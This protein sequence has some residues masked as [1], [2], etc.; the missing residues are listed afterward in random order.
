VREMVAEATDSH[1]HCNCRDAD[2]MCD[3]C[4]YMAWMEDM[5]EEG[6]VCEDGGYKPYKKD[7][8]CPKPAWDHTNC[9]LSQEECV[10][11]EIPF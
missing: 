2:D 10:E 8:V 11:D 6:V 5:K 3:Y 4:S 1:S 9:Y 7:T